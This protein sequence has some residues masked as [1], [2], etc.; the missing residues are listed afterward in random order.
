MLTEFIKD[1]NNLSMREQFGW[2][3]EECLTQK[4]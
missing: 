4:E 1:W 2:P 3:I